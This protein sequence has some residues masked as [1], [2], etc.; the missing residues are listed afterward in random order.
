MTE[1]ISAKDYVDARVDGIATIVV[2]IKSD[3]AALRADSSREHA[4]VRACLATLDEKIGHL[5]T[6]DQVQ[7]GVAAA[8]KDHTD[9]SRAWLMAACALVGAIVAV[10][11][12][13][14]LPG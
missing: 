8:L 1:D 3:L 9:R 14:G 7:A 10:V 13:Y 12:L 4:E 11:G 5:D 6:A 2:D